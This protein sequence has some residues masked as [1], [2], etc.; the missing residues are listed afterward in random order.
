MTTTE[1]RATAATHSK[2]HLAVAENYFFPF[3]FSRASNIGTNALLLMQ[4]L[5]PD[6]LTRLHVSRAP[7]RIT[8]ENLLHFPSICKQC[9]HVK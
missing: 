5:P 6:F 9:L 7:T 1:E 8:R 4:P 2:K 3:S